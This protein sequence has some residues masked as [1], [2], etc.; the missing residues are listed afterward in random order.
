MEIEL[1]YGREGARIEV[2]EANLAGVLAPEWPAPLARPREAVLQALA[3]PVVGPS[4]AEVVR[5]HVA[6]RAATGAQALDSALPCDAREFTVVIL[7]SD[8]TRPCPNADVLGP[9]LSVVRLAG[10]PAECVTILIATGLHGPLVG[11]DVRDLLGP[12]IA[13]SYRVVNHFSGRSSTLASLGSTASGT[14][15]ALAREW[16]DADVRIA[17]GVV[18]P[19]LMA[20]F[21]GGRKAVC[22]GIAGQAT[23]RAWHAPRFL[24]DERVMP[25]VLEGNP[26]HE[27]AL[28]V[29][30]LAPPHFTVNVTVDREVRATGVFA[31]EMRGSHEAAVAHL[32]QHVARPV[33][34]PC[35]IIV[36][37]SGGWP[38]D[39]TFYGAEKG[40]LTGLPILAEGGTF[41]W[42]AACEDGLGSDSF[43]DLVMRYR[44][45]EEFLSAI[46]AEGAS[47]E[48]DQWALENLSKA[49][50]RAELVFWSDRLPREVQTHCF[51]TPV[52]S[53]A[54][55]LEWAFQKHGREARVAVMPYGPYVLPYVEGA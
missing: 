51:V 18:E 49:A 26:E 19:H 52:D 42:A 35:D 43:A 31:G 16:V 32:R 4:L 12:E 5:E 40:L 29:A 21:S 1:A 48:R 15:V 55:G 17:T 24:E 38:L 44:T 2:P 7:V 39:A 10:V 34:G 28:A 54:A 6:A 47:V 14:P 30:D 45:L 25:G 23:V 11:D 13:S 8:L 20:G 46:T 41:V 9:I 22:P 37:T 33:D 3:E 36:T 50:R 27:E 53:L